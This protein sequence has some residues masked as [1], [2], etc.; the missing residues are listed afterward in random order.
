MNRKDAIY[1]VIAEPTTERLASAPNSAFNLVALAR[2]QCELQHDADRQAIAII[3]MPNRREVWRV[4][5]SGF[6]DWRRAGIPGFR[7][8]T[9][10][11]ENPSSRR[12][13]RLP[14]V[15]SIRTPVSNPTASGCCAAGRT[16]NPF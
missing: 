3:P 1:H 9:I 10:Y 6:A 15:C 4:H 5:S 13:A 12:G 7:D 14:S 11:A 2:S 8:S 16:R